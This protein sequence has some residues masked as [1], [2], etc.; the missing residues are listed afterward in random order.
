MTWDATLYGGHAETGVASP[1]TMWYFA[2]GA[3]HSGFDLFY[4]VQNPA[5]TFGRVDVT[6]LLP[7]GAP[8]ERSYA[9]APNSR[10]NIWVNRESPRLAATDVSAVFVSDTSRR[11]RT[12]DVSDAAGQ[13]VR[14]RSC[15]R[16]R[17]IT[18]TRV[19]SRRRSDRPVLRSVRAHCQRG[20]A[21][22][23]CSRDLPAAG[24]H[25]HRQEPTVSPK[26]RTTIWVDNEDTRLAGTSVSTTWNR[27]MARRFS[28]SGRCGGRGTVHMVRGPCGGGHHTAARW[29]LAEGETGG[30]DGTSTFILV[31]N[32]S[33]SPGDFR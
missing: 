3:T 15:E 18:G 28:S 27:P 23:R 4:L 22:S 16:R 9:V 33:A 17:H 6:Y 1:S 2:E 30:E 13:A 12:R 26:S 7:S 20:D 21:A 8:V 11:R 10:F 24:W 25:D 5:N 31:S 29:A 19:V 14:C 32:V